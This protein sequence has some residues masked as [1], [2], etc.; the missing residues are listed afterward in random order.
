M[1]ELFL[2]TIPVV[3]LDNLSCAVK[4]LKSD[5]LYRME[6]VI[7]SCDGRKDKTLVSIQKEGKF[8]RK[9]V[10]EDHYVILLEPGSDYFGHVTCESSTAKGIKSTILT[11]L[12]SK[13]VELGEIFV[14]GCDG[15]VVKTGCKGGVIRLMEEL[16]K[17][18][19]WVCLLVT[20]E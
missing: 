1:L 2:Q 4:E 7:K 16:K 15:T 13:S 19:Q 10:T 6:I 8:Y 3:S 9:R 12:K 14:V 11:Y 17:P 5:Q 18:L 20:F